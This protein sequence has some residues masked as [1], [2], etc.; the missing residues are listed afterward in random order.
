M[1][2]DGEAVGVDDAPEHVAQLLAPVRRPSTLAL[3]HAFV[4]KLDRVLQVCRLRRK[5]HRAIGGAEGEALAALLQRVHRRGQ[6]PLELLL[7][8]AQQ[9][10]ELIAAQPVRAPVFVHRSL[11][12]GPEAS[13]QCVAGEMA[14][15]VVVALEAIQVEQRKHQRS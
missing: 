8:G 3:V 11:Q 2:L 7:G 12:L 15:R 5:R 4:C 13:Q 14:L 10:A 9:H 6:S 1:G